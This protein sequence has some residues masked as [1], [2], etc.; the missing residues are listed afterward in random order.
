VLRG[1]PGRGQDLLAATVGEE[2]LL[3]PVGLD[4]GVHVGVAQQPRDC[5]AEAARPPVV[6]HH[7]DQPVRGGG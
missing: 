4:R 6:L 5:V 3:E 7:R 2:L 1:E